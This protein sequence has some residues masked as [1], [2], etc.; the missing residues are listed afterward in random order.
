[1]PPEVSVVVESYNHAEGSELE[2][3][4]HSELVELLESR[5]PAA[6]R[7]ETKGLGYDR[8]KMRAAEEARSPFVALARRLGRLR[9]IRG[10]MDGRGLR[11][12]VLMDYGKPDLDAGTRALLRQVY[13]AHDGRLRV[14]LDRPPPWEGAA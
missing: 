11:L 5:F 13:A 14:L 8:A 3:F 7:V 2:R 4:A 1:M 6:R 10:L 12:H 9:T